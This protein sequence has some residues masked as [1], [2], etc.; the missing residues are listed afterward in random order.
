MLLIFGCAPQIGIFCSICYWKK[1]LA[2]E[3]L[4]G[5]VQ[6]YSKN[7]K[8]SLKNWKKCIFSILGGPNRLPGGWGG[9]GR[10][11]GLPWC[12]TPNQ[13]GSPQKKISDQAQ[14]LSSQN[15]QS[16]MMQK[17]RTTLVLREKLDK[18]IT[19]WRDKIGQN[20]FYKKWAIFV[21]A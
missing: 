14:P 9:L 11:F 13:C 3:S 5:Y 17:K 8:F 6:K 21:A 2:S 4:P 15:E 1:F 10:L 19:F 20:F 18:T 12:F 7:E 16:K